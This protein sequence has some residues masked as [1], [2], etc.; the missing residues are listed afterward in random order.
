MMLA[1]LWI[2]DD[3]SEAL[4]GTLYGSIFHIGIFEGKI[5]S[6]K[7]E[8]NQQWNERFSALLL[9]LGT[10]VHTLIQSFNRVETI[11]AILTE[12]GDNLKAISHLMKQ[13]HLDTKQR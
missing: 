2:Y 5:P 4:H 6:S 3:S 13:F 12:S 7:E 8:L 1:I 10:C 11:R 9:S